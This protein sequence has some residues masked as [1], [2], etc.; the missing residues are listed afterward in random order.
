MIRVIE[1]DHALIKSM[2]IAEQRKMASKTL[3]KRRKQTMGSI[4]IFLFW[5]DL[6][7]LIPIPCSTIFKEV[8][9][10]K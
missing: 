1:G 8:I 7:N 6:R 5:E 2:I 4:C 3:L 9:V 10:R